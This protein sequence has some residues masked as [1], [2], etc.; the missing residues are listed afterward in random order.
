MFIEALID[1]IPGEN[2]SA[3]MCDNPMNVLMQ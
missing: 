3:E 1:Y 2:L